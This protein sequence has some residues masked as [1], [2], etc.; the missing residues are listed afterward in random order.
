MIMYNIYHIKPHTYD[1]N[2]EDINPENNDGRCHIRKVL[3]IYLYIL[4]KLG[5]NYIIGFAQRP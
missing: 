3:V 1:T 5:T 4:L 2:I